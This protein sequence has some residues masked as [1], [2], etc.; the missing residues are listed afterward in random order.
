LDVFFSSN[1]PDAFVPVSDVTD[2]VLIVNALD[3][4]NN[5]VIAV[6]DVFG[7]VVSGVVIILV[8]N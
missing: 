2:I 5:V 1:F 7:V 6:D 4:V 3:V 8:V